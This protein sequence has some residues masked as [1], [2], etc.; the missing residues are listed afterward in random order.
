M[1]FQHRCQCPELKS[2]CPACLAERGNSHKSIG[3]A[4]RP[5]PDRERLPPAHDCI[6]AELRAGLR[7]WEIAQAHKVS[8]DVLMGYLKSAGLY[9]PRE[10]GR[11]ISE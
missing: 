9:G 5:S 7:Y 8:V 6:V 10:R 3:G 1:A 4:G 2:T 11:E